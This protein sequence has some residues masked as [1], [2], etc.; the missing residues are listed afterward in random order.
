MELVRFGNDGYP[1]FISSRTVSEITPTISGKSDL[2]FTTPV[3]MDTAM[4]QAAGTE[5][6]EHMKPS[7][8]VSALKRI[9]DI[10]VGLIGT[11][12]FVIAYPILALLIKLESQGPALYRQSRVGLDKRSSLGNLADTRRGT[13]VGGRPF[14]IC[15]FRTMRNDA[16]KNG[17]QLC[18]KGGD[19]RVT[20]LGRILRSTHLDEL[21]QF[22]NVL[23][24]EMSFIGPRPERPHFTVRYFQ[25]IPMY[26]ERTRYVKPGITGLSQIVLGYDDSLESVARKTHF[27]LAYRASMSNLAAWLK[28]EFWVMFNTFRYLAQRGPLTE[29]AAL[30][31]L[32]RLNL[33]NL[34]R[35]RMAMVRHR[36][37]MKP[38]LVLA[39]SLRTPTARDEVRDVSPAESASQAKAASPV[40]NFFTVDV[41][42]WF[43]AHNLH[44]PRSAWE[45]SKTRVVENVRRILNLLAAHDSKAT[46]FVLGWVAA[47]YP[48]VV[49]M[50]DVAGHEI[51]THGYYH[52]KVTDMTQ[53]QF[54]KDLDMSLDTLSRY[55]SQKIIG[56]RASNFSI[57]ES[58]MWALDIMAR[59]GIEYDSSIFPV[60]RKR[61]GIPSYPNRLPHVIDLGGG[62]SI[63]EVPLSVADVGGRTLPISGGGYLRLYPHAVTD[64][65]IGRQNAQG[66]PAMLYLH[67][68]E[69]DTEQK[70]VSAGLLESFQH[71]VNLDTTEWK[72][73]R[74]LRKHRFDSIRSNLESG[75]VQAMLARNP[76]SARFARPMAT[77]MESKNPASARP[78]AIS[79]EGLLAA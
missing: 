46:F 74:L 48:E 20:R 21:P 69:V 2:V 72:L 12:A 38:T 60:K 64:L 11:A 62:S 10:A 33:E 28:M 68:W 5:G 16:E 70:R 31:A 15:K 49:R 25:E 50:I 78:H 30:P 1:A 42:C 45:G 61:Y 40:A 54:E 53:Y 9:L 22:W 36:G 79:P 23:K 44:V 35:P 8:A 73:D 57:V 76:V 7:T 19:P 43:H 47:R 52:E 17:P 58:T 39:K 51:G 14:T 18:G 75:P 13:D 66:R 34:G 56:H 71:Y 26:R 55:T 32:G 6:K 3:S 37:E 4:K 27:D 41:E 65:Y 59:Y 77:T 67:P 24:G 29:S 63:R